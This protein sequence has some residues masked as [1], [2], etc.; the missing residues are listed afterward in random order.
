MTDRRRRTPVQ[1][2][3]PSC[4]HLGQWLSPWCPTH[5]PVAVRELR[6]AV[7]QARRERIAAD[8]LPPADPYQTA[9][10]LLGGTTQEGDRR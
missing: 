10:I 9:S 1:C 5:H 2:A 6:A 8:N 4:P 7:D 3:W